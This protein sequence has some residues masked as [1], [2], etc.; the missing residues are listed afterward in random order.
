MQKQAMALSPNRFLKDRSNLIFEKASNYPLLLI[1]IHWFCLAAMNF[2]YWPYLGF[3]IAGITFIPQDRV[4]MTSALNILFFLVTGGLLS[5]TLPG[6]D[7][8]VVY[9]QFPLW[10]VLSASALIAG[11][12]FALYRLML[13]FKFFRHPLLF[14]LGLILLFGYLTVLCRP[15]LTLY[16]FFVAC[17]TGMVRVFWSTCYQLS[18]VDFLSS[19]PFFHHLGT[20]AF[21]WQFGW[22]SPNI[23]RGYSDLKN[24]APASQE[25]FRLAQLSGL[26]LMISALIV[27]L[28]AD[29]FAEFFFTRVTAGGEL[30]PSTFSMWLGRDFSTSAYLNRELPIGLSWVFIFLTSIHFALALASSTNAAVSIARMCGFMVFRHVYRPLQATSFNNFLGRMYYYYI[31]ILLRFIFYPLWQ[32]LRPIRNRRVRIFL[33]NFLT[34]ALGGFLTTALRYGPFTVY[35]GFDTLPGEVIFRWPYIVT[36]SVISA[37]SS[38]LPDCP[39]GRPF[40]GLW[41]FSIYTLCFAL[42]LRFYD[43]TTADAWNAFK[44]LFS[45]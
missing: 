21:P 25:E 22:A 35:Q 40:R 43:T 13:R 37:T 11:I 1:V 33:T 32:H 10:V 3:F 36:L 20:L 45:L 5:A 4:W 18:E 38:F 16:F 7:S 44:H 8:Q 17:F 29:A 30:N 27:G 24:A 28:T 6:V 39:F 41:Y 23:V 34:I 31:A 9:Q 26:K 2:P 15:N 42:Q 12:Y 19:R 14:G